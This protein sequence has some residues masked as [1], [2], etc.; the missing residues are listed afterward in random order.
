MDAVIGGEDRDGR[1]RGDGRWADAGDGGEPDGDVLE[2]AERAARLGQG[3]L[4]GAGLRGGGR[5]AGPD[6]G[7][8]AVE[9][10][11]VGTPETYGTGVG[12]RCQGSS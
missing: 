7:E 11:G 1:R 8:D 5:V 4:A 12:A 10:G 2:D 9:A 3:V 6:G